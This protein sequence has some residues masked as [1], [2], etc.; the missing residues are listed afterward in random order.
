[1]RRFHYAGGS[2]VVSDQVCK[3]I[4]RYARALARSD[5]SD[6]IVVP[7]FT[8]DFGTGLSHIVLG[9]ASQIISVPAPDL[10]VAIE[11]AHTVEILEGRTRSLDP[12]RPDWGEEITDIVDLKAYDWGL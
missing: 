1:M 11:D 3:A 5:T 2:I 7:S 8:D 10:E 6:I 12:E 9:P 4:L